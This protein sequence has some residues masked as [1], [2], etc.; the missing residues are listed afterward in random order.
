MDLAA[1]IRSSGRKRRADPQDMDYP[2]CELNINRERASELGLNQKEV[3][4]NVIT[5]LTSE[6]ND[7]AKL[8]DRSENRKRLHADRAVLR[9]ADSQPCSIFRNIPLRGAGLEATHA[10]GSSGRDRPINSPTEMDHYQ[11]RRVIDIYVMPTT[12]D[13]AKVI[14]HRGNC[15][16]HQTAAQRQ[17]KLRGTVLGMRES[18]TF[19]I[20]LVLSTVLV[21]LIL[22]AQFRSFLDPV[23]ILLA[24]PP[25]ITGVLLILIVTQ[26]NAEHDVADGRDHDDR[27]RR[28]QQHFNR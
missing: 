2:A 12:E 27:N 10:A 28:V 11:I 16:A 21:Y 8:L 17:I 14:R 24:V 25:G 18:F 22:V 6:R 7:R 1:Q 26:H 15:Q 5:A 13:L 23:L 19:G 3:M 4:D 9:E 20:G